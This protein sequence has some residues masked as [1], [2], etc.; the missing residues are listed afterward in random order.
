MKKE[1]R[2]QIQTSFFKL[3][4]TGFRLPGLPTGRKLSNLLDERELILQLKNGNESAFRQLVELFQHR[5]YNTVL[6]IIQSQEDAEDL[7]QEVFI[8][9]YRSVHLFK[10]EAKVSTWMYR[11]ASNKALE[12]LRKKKTQKRFAFVRSLFVQNDEPEIQPGHFDHPGVQLENKERGRV[13]FAAIDK[14]PDNQRVAYVLC[15]LEGLSYQEICESMELSKS[16][17]ESLLFRAKQNLRK[18]LK[19]FYEQDYE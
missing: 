2:F 8:E 5:V 1:D 15:N 9:V 3:Q 10:G 16:S 17:V 6:S 12:F 7:C 14:L 4:A 11:I 19:D 18:L 13:L